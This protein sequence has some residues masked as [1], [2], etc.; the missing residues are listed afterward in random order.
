MITIYYWPCGTWCLPFEL[1]AFNHLSDDFGTLRVSPVM[2]D[3]QIGR[4]V[5]KLLTIGE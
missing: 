1:E 4:L 3:A 5:A 2:N